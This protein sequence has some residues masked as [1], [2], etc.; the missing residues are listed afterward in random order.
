MKNRLL[1]LFLLFSI[2]FNIV[3]AYVIEALDTHPCQ[4]NEY[5]QEFHDENN[6]PADDICHLHHF[7]H[8]AFI[9]PEIDE[10]Q[11]H[12]HLTTKPS[13]K[14]KHYKYNSYKNFLKP[15]INA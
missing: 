15:P 3:H 11:T 10:I 4:V 13:T 12:E 9:L 2:S 14:A 6:I 7:F 8:I 1:T 5:I